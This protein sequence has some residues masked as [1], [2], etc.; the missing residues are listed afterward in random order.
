MSRILAIGDPHLPAE[1][2]KYRQFC[3][4]IYK[5]YRCNMAVIIGDAVDQQAIS[6]HQKNPRAASPADEYKVT[7][8]AIQKWYRDFPKAKVCIGNHDN[9]IHRI[10]ESAGI[11]QDFVKGFKELWK[12]PNWEW[13]FEYIIDDVY[14]THGHGAR[15]VHPA[16]TLSGKMLMSVVIGHCHS[17]A[18]V[19]WRVNPQKRIF[20]MDVGC[21]VDRNTIAM[22]YGRFY[23][24]KP[25]LSCGVVL[26]GIPH[27]IIMPCGPGEKY[28]RSKK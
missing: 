19:K 20:A 24:E 22:E 26:D 1:H 4:D 27:H 10:A 2:P 12:T 21:G 28:H 13:E 11:P 23:T 3:K 18:G 9:R 7:L 15:G 16:W 14:Y 8:V 25:I 5:K 6:F 17:R